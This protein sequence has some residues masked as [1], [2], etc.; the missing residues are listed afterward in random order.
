MAN[1]QSPFAPPQID[2]SA[3]ANLPNIYQQGKE[4]Y[5]QQKLRDAFAGG[6]PMQGGVT[7]W[8]AMSQIFAQ[9]G[10]PV[11]AAN[12]MSRQPTSLDMREQEARIKKM[13]A[14]AGAPKP[15]H[16]QKAVDSVFAKD[17]ASWTA[18]GGFADVKKQLNQLRSVHTDLSSKDRKDDLT[19]F[20]PGILPDSIAPYVG[21]ESAVATREAVEEVVQRSLRAILGAQFTEKEGER[22]IARA[23]NPRL[24]QAENAKRV[25][26]LLTQLEDAADAKNEAIKYFEQNGTLSGWQG[27]LLTSTDSIDL[28]SDITPIEVP[29]GG[30]GQQGATQYREGETAT[31]PQTGEKIIFKN[32]QWMPMQ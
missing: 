11:A 28:D 8:N 3:L 24:S 10:E 13:E 16:G 2:F 15:T 23:Y 18:G 4:N 21:Y 5:R 25:G 17:F 29:Q 6:I 32:G 19:G 31:N 14:E 30:G 9:H 27:S 26:R 20:V 1:Y 7:D 12:M 22:L